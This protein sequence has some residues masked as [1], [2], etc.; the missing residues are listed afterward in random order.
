MYKYIYIE[1]E[2][3]LEYFYNIHFLFKYLNSGS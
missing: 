1:R 2:G 3:E